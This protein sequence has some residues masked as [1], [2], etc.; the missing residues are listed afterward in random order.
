[1]HLLGATGI[2]LY[3][4]YSNHLFDGWF[5]IFLYADQAYKLATGNRKSESFSVTFD[6]T[7]ILVF[8]N[9]KVVQKNQQF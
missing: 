9:L 4:A 6:F 2:S 5:V 8:D 7:W 3:R 1:V